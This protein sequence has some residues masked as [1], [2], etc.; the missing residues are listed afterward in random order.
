M[1]YASSPASSAAVQDMMEVLN[2]NEGVD[3]DDGRSVVKL[4]DGQVKMFV[5]MTVN[6]A[7]CGM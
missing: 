1:K 2:N 7:Q 3:A 6:S 5:R 4:L